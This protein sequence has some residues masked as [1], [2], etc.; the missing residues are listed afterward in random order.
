MSRTFFSVAESQARRFSQRAFPMAM[1][2]MKR[3][4]DDEQ[5]DKKNGMEKG[6]V[7]IAPQGSRGHLRHHDRAAAAGLH[8]FAGAAF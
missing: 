5:A 4:F 8:H 7:L 1:S 2:D 3:C 6:P